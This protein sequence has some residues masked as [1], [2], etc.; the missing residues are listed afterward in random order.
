MSVLVECYMK[1]VVK[2][3]L[4]LVSHTSGLFVPAY[5]IISSHLIVSVP[6]HIPWYHAN[7][8][9]IKILLRHRYSGTM[10][11]MGIWCIID[12]KLRYPV[13]QASGKI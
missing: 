2:L 1:F 5:T 8:E 13:E 12:S 6:I 10:R 7:S 4:C 3:V 9:N 11:F